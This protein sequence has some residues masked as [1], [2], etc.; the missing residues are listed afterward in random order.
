MFSVLTD[1][2]AA[3]RRLTASANGAAYDADQFRAQLRADFGYTA[4][5]PPALEHKD[6]DADVPKGRGRKDKAA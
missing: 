1:F 4:A 5:P 2:F 6:A 3:L